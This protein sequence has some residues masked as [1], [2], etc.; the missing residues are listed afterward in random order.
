MICSSAHS[1]SSESPVHF[2]AAEGDK[3]RVDPALRIATLADL[4]PHVRGFT[5]Q[6]ADYTIIS[7]PESVDVLVVTGFGADE[8]RHV[9]MIPN[10]LDRR[11]GSS[12]GP[13]LQAAVGRPFRGARTMGTR[14]AGGGLK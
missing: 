5:F 7:C 12:P 4:Q 9:E 1:C 8:I 11:R 6:G 10:G 14:T 13:L 3:I 2:S